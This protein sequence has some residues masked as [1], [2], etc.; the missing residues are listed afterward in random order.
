MKLKELT[1]K[2][3]LSNFK[4]VIPEIQREYVWGSNKTVLENFLSKLND[5]L[6]ISEFSEQLEIKTPNNIPVLKKQLENSLTKVNNLY[7]TNIGFLYSYD[8]GNN[9]H[10]IID[11]QQRL[12]TIV[13]LL[14]FYYVKEGKKSD[15]RDLLNTFGTF[16]NF[17][18]RVRP[19]ASKTAKYTF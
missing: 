15:F 1:I 5:S 18:Y 19:L 8:A 3:L 6:S 4:L 9:E 7:E 2:D 10:Y 13:L 12:T 17:S 14:Y 11:G 16:M